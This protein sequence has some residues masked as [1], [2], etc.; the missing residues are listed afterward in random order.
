MRMVLYYLRHQLVER[1]LH[2][3][4]AL[5][6]VT[7]HFLVSFPCVCPEP[8]LADILLFSIKRSEIDPK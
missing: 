6:V 4:L 3:L 7:A 5:C 2:Y 1:A 8:V